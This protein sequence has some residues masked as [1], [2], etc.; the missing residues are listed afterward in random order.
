[1]DGAAEAFWSAA[2]PGF[3]FATAPRGS[4]EFFE[5][6]ERHR[7]TLEPHIPEI[8]GFERWTGRDVLEA[9]CGVATDGLQFARAGARYTGLDLS[10]VALDLAQRRFELEGA[11][12]RF[13]RGSVTDL[14][15]D[16]ES[17]DVVYSHGVIH[18][19][20]D[21]RG[22]VDELHRVLRP[23][24]SALVMVY[25]RG[26]L[27]YHFNIM[28]V[29]RLLAALLLV[30]SAQ[31]AVA[32]VTGE[33]PRLVAAHAQLLRSHGLRYLRDRGLFLSKN[34][35]GPGNP[36]SKVFSR[37]EAL[38]LFGSFRDVRFETRFLNLRIYPGGARLASTSLARRL[39]RRIGWFLYVEGRK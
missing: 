31:R 9:G 16:D 1:M 17:F 7:Y 6:V 25:H 34:T 28:L 29:R 35:D 12:G 18:H 5:Q 33:D 32:R 24:G 23:G 14:P 19:V 11:E 37:R 21:T 36:L 30:P 38:E 2:Q 27:N 3:R 4:R 22:A 8:V 13:I 20:D 15:F 26:S 10:P 39:E